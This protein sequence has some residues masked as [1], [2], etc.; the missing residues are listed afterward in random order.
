[1]G[2]VLA[3]LLTFFG[4]LVFHISSSTFAASSHTLFVNHTIVGSNS[5]CASPGYNSVQSAVDAANKGDTVYLC[6]TIPY[7][8]QVIITKAITLKGDPGATIQAPAVFTTTAAQLPPQFATDNLF[9][10]QAI[11]IVWGAGSNANITNLNINGPL[12]GNNSCA[13]DEYGVLV[14]AGGKVSLTGDHVTNIHDTNPALYGCQFGVGIQIGREY[15]P[16]ADFSTSLVENFVGQATITKTTVTGYQ[17]NGIDID[18]PGSKGNIT[19]STVQGA[20]RDAVFSV[21]IAQNGIQISRGAAGSIESNTIANNSY[22][23]TAPNASSGGIIIFGGC[24]DPL[25][26]N[27]EIQENVLSNNDVGVYLNSYTADPNCTAPAS[28]KTN[29]EVTNNKI[30]NDAITN[31]SSFTASNGT[32]YSGYQAGVDDIGNNDVISHNTISGIGYTPAQTTPGGVFIIP[33]DIITF[34]TIHPQISSNKIG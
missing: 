9:I 24:G 17:K 15:W 34:P 13:D 25:S 10:P 22:T 28:Q 2:P 12:P 8:E 33:I 30:S 27:I 29:E 11:V 26:K 31:K 20:G 32:T 4:M 23:G 1:M 18:G 5:S 7:L 3:L 6:G 19:K 21:I 16:K 14:L